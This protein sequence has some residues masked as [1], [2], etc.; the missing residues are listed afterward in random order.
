[1]IGIGVDV[2]ADGVL[3]PAVAM[4]QPGMVAGDDDDQRARHEGVVG[5]QRGAGIDD[6]VEQV[7]GGLAQEVDDIVRRLGLEHEDGRRPVVEALGIDRRP[8][9]DG[10]ILGEAVG[11][12]GLG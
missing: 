5:A 4:Q 1:M 8:G 3:V 2:L 9:A 6:A 11:V 12:L 7:A 10:R